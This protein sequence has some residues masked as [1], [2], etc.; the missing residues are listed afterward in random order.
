V[1]QEHAVAVAIP[2]LLQGEESRRHLKELFD[3]AH[4]QRYSHSAPEEEADVVSIRVS[5]RGRLPKP[6]LP[7]ASNEQRAAG[8]ERSP[9]PPPAAERSPRSVIFDSSPVLCRVFDRA[10]LAPGNRIRGPALIEEAASVTVLGPGDSA[11]VN[12]FGH[13]VISLRLE[14]AE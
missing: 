9:E 5:A 2:A 12:E 6:A 8:N 13:L 10:R 11:V 4:D 7:P 14:E 1:G 3:A